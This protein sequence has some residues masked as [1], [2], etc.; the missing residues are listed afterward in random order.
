LVA[1]CSRDLAESDAFARATIVVH[2]DADLLAGGDGIA[3]VTGGS[4]LAPSVLQRLACD[5]N[6]TILPVGP[7]GRPVVGYGRTKRLADA[8]LTNLIRQRDGGCRFPGCGR[9]IFT[10]AHHLDGWHAELGRTDLPRLAELCVFHHHFVHE[11]GWVITGSADGE[12]TF[13]SPEG[14]VLSSRPQ[15]LRPD[16]RRRLFGEDPI[17]DGEPPPSVGPPYDPSPPGRDDGS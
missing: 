8:K 11:G 13:T 15:P 9:R 5:C 16:V 17:P 4:L 14:R 10:N 7:D 12:L 2:A 3:E 6:V 1:F